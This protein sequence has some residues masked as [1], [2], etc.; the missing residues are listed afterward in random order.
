MVVGVALVAVGN[1]AFVLTEAAH[2]ETFPSSCA[3]APADFTPPMPNDAAIETRELRQDL[4]A[5]CETLTARSDGE[6]ARLDLGWWG[7]WATVGVLLGL[8][9]APMMER[10]F[11]WW[12]E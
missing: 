11:R 1:G 10:A 9:V 5:L 3:S 7:A 8:V 4:A 12:R 6:L 2:A